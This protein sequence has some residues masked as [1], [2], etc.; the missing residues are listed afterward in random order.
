MFISIITGFVIYANYSEHKRYEEQAV[1]AEQYL[2]EGKFPE[3]VEAYSKALTMKHRNIELLSI[4]LAEAYIG[5]NNFDEALEVLR[6]CYQSTNGTN[7]KEKIEEVTVQKTD[8]E[9]NEII[10]RADMYF[11]NGEYDKAISEYE[12]AKQIKSKEVISYQKIAEAYMEKGDYMTARDEVLEGLEITDKDSLNRTLKTVDT[13]LLNVKYDDILNQAAEYIYQENYEEAIKEY[14]LAIE[15]K[16]KEEVGYSGLAEAY[17][18]LE[19]YEYAISLLNNA[20]DMIESDK[21]QELLEE[22]TQ[23]KDEKEERKRILSGLYNALNQFDIEKIKEFMTSTY[24]VKK[25]VST[26]PVYY[27]ALGEGDLSLGQGMIIYDTSSVYYGGMKDG[28]RT[29]SG[30]YFMLT[31]SEEDSG[32]YYYK[33]LWSNNAP[34]G[35]GKTEEVTKTQVNEELIESS[36]VT[37]GYFYR[38]YENGYMKRYFYEN[39]VETGSVSYSMEQGSPLPLPDENGQTI[40]VNGSTEFVIG[41]MIKNG[42]TTEDSYCAK[43]TDI[44]GVKPFIKP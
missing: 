17:I 39:G 10:K 29:G 26:D 4:G 2:K 15:L 7:I 1:M 40:W 19:K 41:Y 24:F 3:A 14:K 20:L 38:G 12:K 36:I 31:G 16:P 8:Y 34:S 21:L 5:V 13:Y 32:Y 22:A 18:S 42:A 28:L 27:S 35:S 25:I 44:W 43:T 11:A 23:L 6:T 37:E 30:L 9:Y 33:G